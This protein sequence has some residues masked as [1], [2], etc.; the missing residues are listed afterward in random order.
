M[1]NSRETPDRNIERP[2]AKTTAHGAPVHERVLKAEPS[3]HDAPNDSAHGFSQDSGYAS[4]GGSAV[5]DEPRKAASDEF[6]R[7]EV[8]QRL[9]N[10]GFTYE[11]QVGDGIVVLSGTG[12]GEQEQQKLRVRLRQVAGVREIRFET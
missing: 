11:V 3:E 6:I 2:D 12:S 7:A 9:A 4:S 10:D 8:A 1:S 5:K